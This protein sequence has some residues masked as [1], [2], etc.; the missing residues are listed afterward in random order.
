MHGKIDIIDS[1]QKASSIFSG[2][3]WCVLRKG[4]SKSLN[5]LSWSYSFASLLVMCLWSSSV[6]LW[7]T[8][9]PID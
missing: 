9:D 1:M 2:L 6:F 4:S 5:H 7:Y 3:E 8:K